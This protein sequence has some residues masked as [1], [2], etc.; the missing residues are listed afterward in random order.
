MT[1]I[2]DVSPTKSNTNA[3]VINHSVIGRMLSIACAPDGQTVY[4]G[5]YSNLWASDDGGKTFEQLAWPQPP[6]GE[7]DVPG[8]LG[9]CIR[10]LMH[11]NTT[12]RAAEVEHVYLD[13]A[14]TLRPDLM[15]ATTT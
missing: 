9:R 4:A 1:Q 8:A 7:F 6:P 5:S 12:R 10:V 14:V 13:G 15:R 11:V 3:T 2:V